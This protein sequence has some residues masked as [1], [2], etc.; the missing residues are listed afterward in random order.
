MTPASIIELLHDF[1]LGSMAPFWT[2]ADD[3]RSTPMNRHSECLPACLKGAKSGSGRPHPVTSTA[4]GKQ[5]R[6]KFIVQFE[7]GPS[8][9]A[10][11]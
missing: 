9:S 5:C 10:Y 7:L 11:D 4:R 8:C 2:W 3:F 1:R 6:R